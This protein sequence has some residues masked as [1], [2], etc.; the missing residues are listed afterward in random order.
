MR[1]RTRWTRADGAGLPVS[2]AL[3]PS[4]QVRSLAATGAPGDAV[5]P[6]DELAS[7][8]AELEY[9]DHPAAPDASDRAWLAADEVREALLVGAGTGTRVRRALRTSPAAG[10][11]DGADDS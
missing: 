1:G 5:P 11:G 8:H 3:T 7:L 10:A 9:S 4:E 6:L 2:G